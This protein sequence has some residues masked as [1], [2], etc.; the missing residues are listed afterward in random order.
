MYDYA[1]IQN[2]KIELKKKIGAKKILKVDP[3]TY[4]KF[5]RPK[6]KVLLKSLR[7]VNKRSARGEDNN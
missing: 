7:H 2:A 3:G 6:F 5:M 4:T 1:D